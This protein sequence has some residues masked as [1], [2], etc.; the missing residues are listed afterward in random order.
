MI[1]A[2]Q[3]KRN[4]PWKTSKST[5]CRGH[6]FHHLVSECFTISDAPHDTPVIEAITIITPSTNALPPY[7]I[8]NMLIWGKMR[9]LINLRS[10]HSTT[11][12]AELQISL[13]SSIPT[14]SILH[15]HIL[16]HV[17]LPAAPARPYK[18][19][20]SWRWNRSNRLVCVSPIPRHVNTQA[21]HPSTPSILYHSPHAYHSGPM[22]YCNDETQS[23]LN[24]FHFWTPFPCALRN[25]LPL[26]PPHFVYWY[27][28]RLA[29][30]MVLINPHQLTL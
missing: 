22:I 27:W 3:N 20:N 10:H 8:Y 29:I 1:E 23:M 13:I 17:Q 21:P 26:Q 25:I 16:P 30:L 4:P 28:I 19:M 9:D 11:N 6:T 5:F 7:G 12:F 24:N 2:S 18:E 15:G 14:H